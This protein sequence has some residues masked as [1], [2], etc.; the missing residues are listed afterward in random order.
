MASR[1]GRTGFLFGLVVGVTACGLAWLLGGDRTASDSDGLELGAAAHPAG[2][3]D[4]LEAR[5]PGAP[6]LSTS[7]PASRIADDLSPDERTF[8]EAALREE[9]RR[10]AAAVIRP[11]DTGLDVYRRILVERSDPAAVFNSFE[12][13]ASHVRPATGKVVPPP[14]PNVRGEINLR[15]AGLEDQAVLELGPGRF[16]IQGG[17]AHVLPKE[18]TSLEIRGAGMKDTVIELRGDLLMMTGSL[19]N[20]TIRDLTIDGGPDGRGMAF[21]LR[22]KMAA[23]MERVRFMRW[24]SGGH[25]AAFGTYG[26]LYLGL[27]DCEFLGGRLGRN[28]GSVAISLRAASV[29]L[30]ERCAFYDTNRAITSDYGRAAESKVAFVDC[31][32]ISTAIGSRYHVEKEIPTAHVEVRGGEASY[33]PPEWDDAMR[34]TGFGLGSVALGADSLRLGPA[35]PAC[36]IGLLKACL[37]AEGVPSGARARSVTLI[38]PARLELPARFEGTWWAMDPP[39]EIT[40]EI[41]WDG[42]Q[43]HLVDPKTSQRHASTEAPDWYATGGLLAVLEEAGLADGEPAGTLQLERQQPWWPSTAT[44]RFM[45][46]HVIDDRSVTSA[47]FDTESGTLYRAPQEL[48]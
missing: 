13:F 47:L 18:M 1:A 24:S 23:T 40:S 37:A 35:T 12:A 38:A 8:L 14:E 36:T 28:S 46:L 15:E 44:K 26:E 20:L 29:I 31:S 48:R 10:R 41:G 22:G 9:R 17:W 4:V 25:G 21:D 6:A 2:A 32:F 7:T 16:V 30:A 5:T 11:E 27:R 34:A 33:G 45:A 39:R 42:R 19:E 3:R 43:A